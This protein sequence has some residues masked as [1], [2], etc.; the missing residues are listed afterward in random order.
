[1]RFDTKKGKPLADWINKATENDIKEVLYK[2]GDEK[3]AKLIANAID[4]AKKKYPI[5]EIFIEEP[6]LSVRKFVDDF[7]C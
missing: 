7:H 3:Y 6:L 4:S 2:Y 5:S 1:M